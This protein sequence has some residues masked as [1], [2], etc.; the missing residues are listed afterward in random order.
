M[1]SKDNNKMLKYAND[2]NGLK[3]LL[4]F[5]IYPEIKIYYVD[6]KVFY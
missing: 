6:P 4:D 5:T 1:F 3:M 2:P